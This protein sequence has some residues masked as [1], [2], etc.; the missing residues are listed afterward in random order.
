MEEHAVNE[1]ALKDNSYPGR[2]IVMGVN[3]AGTHFVQVYWLMGRSDNSRNR[4]FVLEDGSVKTKA[5]DESKVEDPSLI[6]YDAMIEINDNHIVSNGDQT[7]TIVDFLNKNKTFEDALKTRDYEPDAPHFTP[8][9]SGI[10]YPDQSV[11]MSIIRKDNDHT[12]R[13]V[14]NFKADDLLRGTG[15]CMHTYK[16]DGDPLPS[17]DTAPFAVSLFGSVEENA[18][19][20]W[21]LLNPE[22]RISLVVKSI[23]FKGSGP[24]FHIINKNGDMQK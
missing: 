16:G 20:F 11:K 19:K 14:F 18:N 15:Y 3:S 12:D 8:R 10:Y 24:E 6:I 22:N 2:G 9:I 23:P 7:T 17:Y 5:Y 21:S 1:S 4:I 13:D